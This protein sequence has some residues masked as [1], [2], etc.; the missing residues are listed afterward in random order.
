MF[1]FE[2]LIIAMLSA[3]HPE[4][5]TLLTAVRTHLCRQFPRMDVKD[6]YIMAKRLEELAEAY[7]EADKK[8]SFDPLKERA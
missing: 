1:S 5:Q 8:G 6:A 2:K 3:P 4:G 7:L